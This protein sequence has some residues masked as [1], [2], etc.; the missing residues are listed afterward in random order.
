MEDLKKKLIYL[1]NEEIDELIRIGVISLERLQNLEA[2]FPFTLRYPA[3]K[4]S[5]LIRRINSSLEDSTE[6]VSNQSS[7]TIIEPSRDKRYKHINQE[8]YWCSARRSI[9]M[10]KVV[11]T[12]HNYLDENGAVP[13]GNL[14]DHLRM[15]FKIRSFN[16]NKLINVLRELE[17]LDIKFV[18]PFD[19]PT[20]FDD[21]EATE[22]SLKD[23][24]DKLFQIKDA[25]GQEYLSDLLL[26]ANS[27]VDFIR[28]AFDYKRTNSQLNSSLMKNLND[29]VTKGL[30]YDEFKDLIN[31][32]AEFNRLFKYLSPIL[33]SDLIISLIEFYP[34]KNDELFNFIN[35]LDESTVLDYS[36][37]S[38]VSGFMDYLLWI[39]KSKVLNARQSIEEYV[40]NEKNKRNILIYKERTAVGNRS[41]TLEDI[42]LEIGV[43]R[44]RVRQITNKV[45]NKILTSVKMVDEKLLFFDGSGT[46]S[47]NLIKKLFPEYVK[48]V[49]FAFINNE[50]YYLSKSGLE[51]VHTSISDRF[52]TPFL[53]NEYNQFTEEEF[54]IIL[55][56]EVVVD[57][58]K[59]LLNAYYSHLSKNYYRFG[60]FFVH[61][62]LNKYRLLVF[63]V[64]Q[65][66]EDGIKLTDETQMNDLLKFYEDIRGVNDFK[67]VSNRALVARLSDLLDLVGK[68]T[69]T[70]RRNLGELSTFTKSEIHRLAQDILPRP[71][72][73]DYIFEHLDS[74]LVQLDGIRD[75]HHLH[76]LMKVYMQDDYVY[77][78]DYFAHKR[79]D[80]HTAEVEDELLSLNR[81]ITKKDFDAVTTSKSKT[82]FQNLYQSGKWIYLGNKRYLS[83]TILESLEPQLSKLTELVLNLLKMNDVYHLSLLYPYLSE[84]LPILV[85]E[86]GIDNSTALSNLLS[87]VN[88]GYWKQL[89]NYV[90]KNELVISDR[91]DVVKHLIRE[92]EKISI[93]EVYFHVSQ[94]GD[95]VLNGQHLIDGLFPLYSRISQTELMKSS[96][97]R[98][99][100]FELSKIDSMIGSL[101]IL[102]KAIYLSKLKSFDKFP[103]INFEWNEHLLASVI[104][105]NFSHYKILYTDNSYVNTSYLI[106]RSSLGI[107]TFEDYK[108]LGETNE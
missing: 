92:F 96:N 102:R 106:T 10:K 4:R 70:Y 63:L 93:Q 87:Y 81:I 66:F 99:S 76:G 17:A 30:N 50:N 65:Y 86:Y 8:L 2:Y 36:D 24:Y 41:K 12:I 98:L 40:T 80:S 74:N 89:S 61:K 108:L 51:L 19:L 42:G 84:E 54:D 83:K 48:E 32:Q 90:F 85:E 20:M 60:D 16:R 94:I 28:Y 18:K 9:P 57:I 107:D 39:H 37:F 69:Y 75:Y 53:R 34:A 104:K 11:K 35:G 3:S 13:F 55:N 15:H 29:I 31:N 101:L 105:L 77:H 38:Q 5:D 73:Y 58:E 91:F 14:Y 64:D 21:S 82:S 62:R 79:I 26:N 43:T 78:K 46:V 88:K 23:L 95:K 71:V 49:L 72:Y 59:D 68:G 1:N 33:K 22:L 103:S 67:E 44:E 27:F 25:V 45:G 97:I 56:R 47:I 100:D 52:S 7:E 6:V